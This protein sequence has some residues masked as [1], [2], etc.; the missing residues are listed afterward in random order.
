MP[1]AA[2]SL[3]SFMIHSVLPG[4]G[5]RV[6]PLVLPALASFLIRLVLPALASVVIR[7]VL[8]AQP[9]I[10]CVEA[11]PVS[12]CKLASGHF[13]LNSGMHGP[14]VSPPNRAKRSAGAPSDPVGVYHT[15]KQ[16]MQ[17]ASRLESPSEW[18]HQVPDA[19]RRNV[20]RLC[21]EGPL[22]VSKLRLQALSRLNGRLKE[23]EP[24]EAELRSGMHPDV[25]EVTRGKAICLFRELL[26]E[27]GFGDLSV[28]DSLVSGVCLGGVEPEC[29]LFPDPCRF[30]RTSLMHR[31]RSGGR[32][33][34]DASL[35]QTRPTL[36]LSL[37]K[38]LRRLRR[39]I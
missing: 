27:T 37:L 13:S 9:S 25:E 4:L 11:D 5:S 18:A 1:L 32:K 6:I 34:C 24:Q 8:P 23:L 36:M 28:V 20:F 26:E 14:S 10:Y 39:A 22:A 38:L 16:R 33:P 12:M 2:L 31:P 29:P 17:L 21:T 3:A 35:L 15:M 30:I 19:I 7:L